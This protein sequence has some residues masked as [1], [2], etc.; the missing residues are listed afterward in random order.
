MEA[1]NDVEGRLFATFESLARMPGQGRRRRDLT[2]K[3]VLFFP[4]YSYLI[5]YRPD[6]HPLRIYAVLHGAKDVKKAM[7]SRLQ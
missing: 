1:A 3:P 4:V 5:I 2:S 6:T 7:K